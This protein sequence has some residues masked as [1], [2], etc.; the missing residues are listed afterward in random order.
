M[1][2]FCSNPVHIFSLYFPYSLVRFLPP[3]SGFCSCSSCCATYQRDSTIGPDGTVYIVGV[4][5]FDPDEC[6]GMILALS[7]IDILGKFGVRSSGA[8][9][10]ST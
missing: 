3:F 8:R 5:S 7:L 4:I 9:C 10:L 1:Y 6:M 2:F